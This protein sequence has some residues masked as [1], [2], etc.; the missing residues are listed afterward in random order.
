MYDQ[1][2]VDIVAKKDRKKPKKTLNKIF[3][4]A[5][6]TKAPKTKGTHKMPDGSTMSGKTHTT[7]SKLIKGPSKS[8]KGRRSKY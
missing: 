2:I 8:M 4:G 1:R 5:K 6:K 3:K 7:T